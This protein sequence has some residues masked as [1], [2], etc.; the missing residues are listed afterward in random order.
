[1]YIFLESV[2]DLSLVASD[3]SRMP[4]LPLIPTAWPGL[5]EVTLIDHLRGRN[6]LVRVVVVLVL[7]LSVAI[8]PFYFG[9][10]QSLQVCYTRV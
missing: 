5:V 4:G 3:A 9:G 7:L 2:S 8:V 10:S 1:M 6:L